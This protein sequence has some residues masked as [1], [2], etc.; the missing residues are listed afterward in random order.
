M[1]YQII[2]EHSP[3]N[4]PANY[5]GRTDQ[6]NIDFEEAHKSGSVKILYW[7]T[8]APEHRMFLLVD[9]R[10]F[11]DIHVML[12]NSM[13][14][15][16]WEIVSVIDVNAQQSIVYKDKVMTHVGFGKIND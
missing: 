5:E 8:N 6:M 16:L 15:G 2:H 4:C 14:W 7:V 1:L 3:E 10:K 13:K 9:A 12:V 11:E